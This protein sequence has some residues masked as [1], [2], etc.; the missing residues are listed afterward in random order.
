ME[1]EEIEKKAV[2]IFVGGL[3]EA[4]TTDDIRRLFESLGTVQSLETIRTKCRN[5]AYLDFLS[6]PKS[7]SKLFSKYNGCVWKGGKLGLEKAKEHYLDRMKKE[8][9]EDKIRSIEASAT[10]ITTQKKELVKEK[11]IS[12]LM[13]FDSFGL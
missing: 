6:D 8:W 4:V 10:E 11:P 13:H 9:E 2:R 1:V 12:R 7:L 3:G 5:L